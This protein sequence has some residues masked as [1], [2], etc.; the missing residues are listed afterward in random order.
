MA[1]VI[2]P[3]PLRKFAD[4]RASF[5]VDGGSVAEAIDALTSEYPDLKKHLL[6]D[7]GSIRN[8]VRI[9]VDDDDIKALNN[10]STAIQSHSVVSIIPAIAGGSN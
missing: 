1:K 7:N 2:I 6:D 10:E 4:N 3:T 5:D 9:Y 8:F